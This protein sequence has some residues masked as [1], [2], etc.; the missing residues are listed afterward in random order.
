M[1]THQWIYS[2][3]GK[4]YSGE[5]KDGHLGKAN[6]VI[7]IIQRGSF[8]TQVKRKTGTNAD[9]VMEFAETLTGSLHMVRLTPQKACQCRL[10]DGVC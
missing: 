9:S 1:I 10:S 2:C 5:Q 7:P 3:R 8:Y 6:D 4:S